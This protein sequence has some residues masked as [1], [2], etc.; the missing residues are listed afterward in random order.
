[1]KLLF[2]SNFIININ[3]FISRTFCYISFH[4]QAFTFILKFK[5]YNKLLLFFS[6]KNLNGKIRMM[7]NLNNFIIFKV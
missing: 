3:I 4:Y 7:Y 2:A 6:Q 1:M 5:K